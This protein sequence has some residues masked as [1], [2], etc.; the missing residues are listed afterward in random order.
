MS[1]AR[2]R[3]RLVEAE[4]VQD[5]TPESYFEALFDQ[6]SDAVVTVNENGTIEAANQAIEELTG[7]LKTE[8]V[9]KLIDVFVPKIGIH[10]IPQRSRAIGRQM[11]L[12]PGTYEDVCVLRKDGHFKFVDFTV[13]KVINDNAVFTLTL[14]RDV[15]EK[16]RMER[17]L[18]TKHTELLEA[19]KAL[20]R[21]NAELKSM[22]ETLVQAGKMAALGELSA[23][24][25]HELNQPLQAIRGFTQE[26]QE[27]AVP[28]LKSLK[29]AE[30]DASVASSLKSI[31]SGVDKMA[32]IIGY[33][34]SFVRKSTEKFEVTQVQDAIE[35]AMTMLGRQFTMRGIEVHKE[36]SR[37]LPGV[38]ANPLQLLQVFINL[39][40]N[41]RDAIEATGRGKGNIWIK[42]SAR[43]EFVEISFR[44]DGAGMNEKTKS[45]VF[46]PFFTTKEVGKGMGLGMSL[47]YGI[48]SKLQASIVVESELGKG[49]EFVIKIPKDYRE[50]A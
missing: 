21:N 19:Y 1:T 15:T 35:E 12:T 32:G 5:E 6:S 42:T 3:L 18:I 10:Q 28:Q 49:A 40:T 24:I 17:E 33:F 26:L 43:E 14:F 2:A 36:F 23:G 16:K 4:S 44:D 46:N 7:Y 30:L 34:R 9:G 39:A 8:L 25:A 47:S 29:N 11:L 41:A 13:R 38:Y 20:E 48:L 45:K 27:V 22:Q 50:L 37:D 31:V